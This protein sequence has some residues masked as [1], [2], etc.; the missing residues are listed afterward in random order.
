MKVDYKNS[1]PHIWLVSLFVLSIW[2]FF[3]WHFISQFSKI[4]RSLLHLYLHFMHNLLYISVK[5]VQWTKICEIYEICTI[6]AKLR[7]QYI[8]DEAFYDFRCETFQNHSCG[9]FSVK[10]YGSR[11]VSSFVFYDWYVYGALDSIGK[12]LLHLDIS[13]MKNGMRRIFFVSL[14]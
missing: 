6:C 11:H 9:D 4:L 8:Y 7:V 14:P 2:S 5:S 1:T 10:L 3:G 12:Q 13:N